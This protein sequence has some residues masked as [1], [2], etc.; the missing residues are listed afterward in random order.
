MT[1]KT[2]PGTGAPSKLT[3]FLQGSTA[4]WYIDEHGAVWKRADSELHPTRTSIVIGRYTVGDRPGAAGAG[5]R[6]FEVRDKHHVPGGT[7][8]PE[9]EH[10]R[11]VDSRTRSASCSNTFDCARPRSTTPGVQSPSSSGAWMGRGGAQPIK[12][13]M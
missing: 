13:T 8:Y 9:A 3:P 1:D 10:T 5:P 7:S 2:I 4:T 12:L 11:V 6:S